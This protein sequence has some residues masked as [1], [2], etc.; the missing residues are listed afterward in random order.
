MQIQPSKCKPGKLVNVLDEPHRELFMLRFLAVL[1]VISLQV[2]CTAMKVVDLSIV[3]GRDVC[4]Y[5]Y[6]DN[7]NQQ[8]SMY[9]QQSYIDVAQVRGLTIDQCAS[10]LGFGLPATCNQFGCYPIATVWCYRAYTDSFQP[11]SSISEV[12]RMDAISG[13]STIEKCEQALGIS[14]P[15][16]CSKDTFKCYSV[17][18]TTGGDVSGSPKNP[19]PPDRSATR[20]SA[21][22]T[23]TGFFV[24]SDVIVSN[25]H[26][27]D[28]C[29]S[30]SIIYKGREYPAGITVIDEAADLSVMRIEDPPTGVKAA[31]IRI[32]PRL[33]NGEDIIVIGFPYGAALGANQKITTG[34]VSSLSG[35]YGDPTNLQITAP[36]QS[37]NSGGP[38]L[39][40]SGSVVGIVV[41]KLNSTY[42]ESITGD[43][44]QNV[45]FAIK[46]SKLIDLLEANEI[47]YSPSLSTD[48]K[49]TE[50]VAGMASDSIAWIQCY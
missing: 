40:R 39:D 42:V 20:R 5:A 49:S 11:L 41:A 25:H 9:S 22:S 1:I 18:N 12:T 3:S 46:A 33:R 15:A 7:W 47:S 26:V 6:T 14:L 43:T 32:Q 8:E 36:V 28:S 30:V 17:A 50:E 10:I 45:N 35:L 38:L 29:S 23:G 44:P 19:S 34:N 2:G 21:A 48:S 37:G 16:T 27:V 4:I 31:T 13:G 24:N